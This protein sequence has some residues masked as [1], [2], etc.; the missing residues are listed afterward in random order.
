MSD[1]SPFVKYAPK[2][3]LVA[4][5][6]GLSCLSQALMQAGVGDVRVPEVL[7]IENDH[8][9][10][11]R[12]HT[13]AASAQ[14]WQQLGEGL[15]AMHRVYVDRVGFE[16]DNFIGASPQPNEVAKN[17]GEFFCDYR[18]KFQVERVA[19]KRL[20]ESFLAQL[21]SQRTTLIAF[22]NDNLGKPCLVHGDFWSGNVMFDDQNIWL[23]D[24]AVYWGDR[25]ADIA[26]SEMF[27][28]FSRAFY[29]AYDGSYPLSKAYPMKRS[30]Y[31]LYH[32]LNHYNL[33]GSGYLSAC[34]TGFKQLNEV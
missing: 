31:N 15:A 10:V 9:S 16:R 32:Y 20:R 13:R 7:A 2:N 26:M 4:E 21:E 8:M 28:G 33:F 25:E 14:Q 17:W 12:I 23:I 22:L 18:L 34:Q 1:D 3:S 19:E 5:A 6:F 30:I 27:G 11:Q 29:S 24:P